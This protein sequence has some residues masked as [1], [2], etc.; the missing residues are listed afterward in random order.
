MSEEDGAA[1]STLLTQL[2]NISLSLNF[3]S[4]STSLKRTLSQTINWASGVQH[5][6]NDV[7]SFLDADIFPEQLF[8]NSSYLSSVAAFEEFLQN[9]IEAKVE[10]EIEKAAIFEQ[11]PENLRIRH[12]I[13]SGKLLSLYENAPDHLSVN[14]SEVCRRLGTCMPEST[15]FELNTNALCFLKNIINLESFLEF[16]SKC[17]CQIDWDVLGRDAAIQKQ[18]GTR[19]TRETAHQLKS[20]FKEMARMRNRI[21]HTGT[22]SDVTPAI[23]DSHLS[24]LRATAITITTV[25]KT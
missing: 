14:F 23:L 20:Y 10:S 24:I 19:G 13:A 3:L 8:F 1:L 22:P 17:C 6:L 12:M 9:T 5:A 16:L 21:A 25:L 2:D 4:L 18:L 11:L 15:D 7:R